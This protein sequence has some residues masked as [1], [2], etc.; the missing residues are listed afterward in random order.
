MSAV[1]QAFSLA[2]Q[3]GE[4]GLCADLISYKCGPAGKWDRSQSRAARGHAKSGFWVLDPAG[5][6][7]ATF[8]AIPPLYIWALT[9]VFQNWREDDFD[10]QISSAERRHGRRC[11]CRTCKDDD[12][13]SNETESCD[14][15]SDDTDRDEHEDSS[16]SEDEGLKPRWTEMG[17]EFTKLIHRQQKRHL[18]G[19]VEA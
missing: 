6:G 2:A 15:E 7:P 4:T 11:E 18:K 14:T 9:R 8:E 16:E 12:T 3:R 5:M 1:S 19:A 17:F 13:E 10:K